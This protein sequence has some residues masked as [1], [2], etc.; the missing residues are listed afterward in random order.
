MAVPIRA[1]QELSRRLLPGARGPR[2]RSRTFGEN[3]RVR[4]S[5]ADGRARA[6]LLIVGG[7]FLVVFA[8]PLFIAPF[9][10]AEWFGWDVG[11]AQG[12]RGDFHRKC[13][14]VVCGPLAPGRSLRLGFRSARIGTAKSEASR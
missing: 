3:H 2:R 14:I 11:V 5:D 4:L 9:T 8:L 1:A 13:G 6:F 10:W 12:H 7:L